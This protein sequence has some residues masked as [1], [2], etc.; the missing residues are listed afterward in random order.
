MSEPT[1]CARARS[2]PNPS[3]AAAY[4]DRCDVLVGLKGFHVLEVAECD[5][6][7]GWWLR[8]VVESPVRV[9]GCPTCGVVAGSH[10]RRNVVLIDIPCFGRPVRLVWRKRTCGAMS[11]R[12][13]GV[14]TEQHPDLA[15]PR[16][17]LIRY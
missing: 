12:P 10:G 4:C 17:I 13:A 9:M 3:S 7:R 16:A 2:C 6:E 14:V 15:R 8:V 5:G 11:R 1:A